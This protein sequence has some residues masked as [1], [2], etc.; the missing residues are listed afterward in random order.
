[1]PFFTMKCRLR[2]RRKEVIM[3]LCASCIRCVMD[4]QEERVRETGTDR[5]RSDYLRGVAGVISQAAPTDSAPV[6][7]DRI[8]RVY[9]EIFGPAED[10]AKIKREFNALMLSL[11][12]QLK[13]KIEAKGEE[14]RL[15]A[16]MLYARAAN[17]IDFGMAGA[18]EKETLLSL[19]DR[20]AGEQLDEKTWEGFLS[21]LAKARSLVYVTDNCGEVVCDRLVIEELSRRFPNLSVTALVRGRDALNDATREDAA[22][23]GLDRVARIADNGCGVA[24]TPLEYVGAE[25]KELLEGAD[26]ILSKGQGNFE[27]M[28]G[29][30]LNVY[31]SFLCKCDW[32]QNR[33]GMEKNRG[34]FITER[35]AALL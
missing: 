19:L 2:R 23:V 29:C 9:E 27:T 6:L 1:M 21:D 7:V 13:E 15:H 14:E 30:G 31:Y 34:V 22:Q 10:Y 24:G 33:F 25:A 5:Q 20:A 18:V 26:V 11:V 3:E 28:H 12:P 4:R 17:Y 32:F 16:A 35:D 8:N